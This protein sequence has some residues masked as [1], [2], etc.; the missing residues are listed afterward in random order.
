M[1]KPPLYGLSTSPRLCETMSLSIGFRRRVVAAFWLGATLVGSCC[2]KVI[3]AA[4]EQTL[5]GPAQS[6]PSLHAHDLGV[7]K[8]YL[9]V[10]RLPPKHHSHTLLLHSLTRLPAGR[11]RYAK[12][13]KRAPLF[14]PSLGPRKSGLPASGA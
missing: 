4:D 6:E 12:R 14:G 7:S 9:L 8:R 11:M 10:T 13:R 2:S 5:G 1:F 3:A